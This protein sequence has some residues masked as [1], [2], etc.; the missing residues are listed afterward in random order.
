MTRNLPIKEMPPVLGVGAASTDATVSPPSQLNFVNLRAWFPLIYNRP[1]QAC[2]Q[3][4]LPSPSCRDGAAAGAK[5]GASPA[6]KGSRKR[7][8]EESRQLQVGKQKLRR[9]EIQKLW[10]TLDNIVPGESEPPPHAL[11]APRI[12]TRCQDACWALTYLTLPGSSCGHRSSSVSSQRTKDQLLLDATN[13]AK[14][15]HL[16]NWGV[17]KRSSR[18]TPHPIPPTAL[19]LNQKPGPACAGLTAGHTARAVTRGLNSTLRAHPYPGLRVVTKTKTR[20]SP[21]AAE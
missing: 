11:T 19:L 2:P 13:R 5:A 10:T 9:G 4:Q 3:Q 1:P 16:S 20:T 6:E 15:I 7:V 18:P 17:N 14:L 12:P 21:L 8:R